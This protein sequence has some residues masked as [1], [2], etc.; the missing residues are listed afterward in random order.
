MYWLIDVCG[1]LIVM[2]SFLFFRQDYVLVI[3][4]LGVYPLLAVTRR[5][6][7]MIHLLLAT[8]IALTWSI[9][10]SGHY[11]YRT[12]MLVFGG[13]H[14]YALFAWALGLFFV[15][16]LFTHLSHMVPKPGWK[17]A[18]LYLAIYWPLLIAAETIAY[19]VFMFRNLGT[20]G[21]AGLPICDCIHAPMWMQFAYLIMGPLHYFACEAIKV[22]SKR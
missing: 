21:Y 5:W 14:L 16:S 20:A 13:I 10:A 19:H 18:L 12:D 7:S 9:I 2:L 17:R 11:T 8:G 4:Y 1:I 15:Y 3:A 6:S 22:G